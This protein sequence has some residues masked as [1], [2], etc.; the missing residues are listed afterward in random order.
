MSISFLYPGALYALLAVPLLLA[1]PFVGRS[2][3]GRTF[4]FGAALALRALVLLG[5][6]FALAG[7]QIVQAVND[8]TVG[9]LVDH[10]DSVPQSEQKRAEEY[11]RTA[12]A[13]MQA[14]DRA[15]VVVFGENA[16]VERLAS[17]E[18]TLDPITSVPRTTRTDLASALRLALALFPE[19]TNKRIVLLSDGLENSNHA[20]ELAEL[21]A[22][23][24]VQIDYVPLHAPTGQAE[25]YIDEL[26][27]PSAVRQGQA[28][29]LI[30]SV[31]STVTGPATLRLSG[32]GRVLETRQLD[33]RAGENRVV[34]SLKADET[35]FRRY[36]VELE[37]SQDTLAQNNAASAFTVVQGPPRVLVVENATGEADN[38]L[39]AL[40]SAKIPAERVAPARVPGDLPSLSNYDAVLL[41]DVPAQALPIDVMNALPAYVR[42]LGRGLVMIGGA[43]SFGAGGYLRT[44]LE[45]ALPVDMDVR[46]RTQEPNLALAFVV[47]KSGSMGRCHCDDPNL[48]PGQYSRVESGLSKVDIAK[49]A[50]MQAARAVGP[51]DY[52]GVVVFDANAYWA[53]RLQALSDP[54]SLQYEIGGVK[55]DGQTNVYAGLSAAE[56]ALRSVQARYKHVV[57][58]TDGWSRTGDF[59]P[60]AT[61]MREEGITLSVVAAGEGSAT[62]LKQLA[63]TGGGRYYAARDMTEVPSLFF[64]ETVEATGSYIIE[65]PFYPL[66]ALPTTI[67]RGLDVAQLPALRGYN[68]T[69]PK[70][71][72][73]VAL[74]TD[75]GDPLL[76]TWQYGLGRAAAWTSDAKGQ[77]ATDWVKWPGFNTFVAQ[78]TNWVLPR[79]EE[80]GLDVAFR[81]EGAQTVLE[82]N[83]RDSSGRPRDLLDTRATI[84]GPDLVSQ[85]ITLTQVASGRYRGELPVGRPGAFLVQLTQ[86]DSSQL[87][88]AGSTTGLVVSY[89]PEYKSLGSAASVL[90]ELARATGGV[91]LQSPTLAF[92]HFP[93]PAS[94]AQPIWPELLLIAALL[95]PLDVAARR[96][97]LTRRDAERAATW[98]SQRLRRSGAVPTGRVLNPLFAARERARS[99]R[100]RD[101]RPAGR[102]SAA[103][104]PPADPPN[105]QRIERQEPQAPAESTP[106]S[107]TERLRK[108]KER[109][110]RT[111]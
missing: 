84:V 25:A 92:E 73:Q 39:A 101:T 108:A 47:D 107:M 109:A 20:Q 19:E 94:R 64:K 18:T 32:D 40:Q 48:L 82:V 5:L 96:L 93:R 79:A 11:V 53:A 67:L 27:A 58:L 28:F 59:D 6:I 54:T 75:R 98:V 62:Y 87:P 1:L 57:L 16:L 23:R 80:G 44:P 38:L 30:A 74:T 45:K 10:S 61:K 105:A 71:S 83:S 88:I 49:D 95:F 106:E 81:A 15:A 9:F 2:A 4:H 100:L 56:E 41:V 85:E 31:K 111:R 51:A 66:P 14:G 99:T 63:Q 86:R 12:V 52:I 77:W 26:Q 17:D 68:G 43:N 8:T 55:A 60:L 37:A 24:G 21:A 46:S 70:A 13:S 90:P 42:D 50:V 102:P 89:S 72:A 78:L 22:A 7:T 29:E 76:A 104:A 34:F 65:E 33:L 103:T 91:E 97:R 3:S 110:K 69:T 36:T 35:G